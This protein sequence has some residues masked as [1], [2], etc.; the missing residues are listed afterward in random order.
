MSLDE[1]NKRATFTDKKVKEL[2]AVLAKALNG[3][4]FAVV[5]G[6]S[7]ARR[8]ASNESDLDFFIIC[9]SRGVAKK[10]TV[11]LSRIAQLLGGIVNK[12]PAAG[13]AFGR[14]EAISD[15]EKNIGGQQDANDKI[16]RRI[17]FLLEGEWL[18]NREGFEKYRKRIL[19][20]YIKNSISEHQL[21]RFLLNDLIRYYRTICV[22]FEYK[23]EEDGK[24]WGTRNLK[25]MF[26]RKL[27]YFSGI[28]VAAE[29][30][31]LSYESKLERTLYLLSLTPIS[32]LQDICG[33]RADHALSIY[34]EFLMAISDKSTRI[35]CEKVTVDR[36]THTARFRGIKNRGHHFT[37][38]LSKLLKDTY[39]SGHP[40]YN[41]LLM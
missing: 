9:D 21:S 4:Q 36:K 33:A 23:T 34:C 25:L 38:A 24:A 15:M 20:K 11:E 5:V 27:L 7:Y 32:R 17:L 41:A 35:H 13:G 39:D 31:Q 22:D 16:T 14:V 2:R 8:E 37:W 6:G 1:I 3:D 19:A 30:A 28:L 18:Y 12:S 29:S 10:L 40:I 26:S